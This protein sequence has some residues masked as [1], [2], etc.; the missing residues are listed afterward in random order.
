MIKIYPLILVLGVAGLYLRAY[1]AG[2]QIN[3]RKNKIAS[4]MAIILIAYVLWE[5]LAHANNMVVTV[6]D[7][8]QKAKVFIAA[9]GLMS[10]I[11]IALLSLTGKQKRIKA[12]TLVC[13]VLFS[14]FEFRSDCKLLHS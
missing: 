9:I 12:P 5:R 11:P 7:Y 13:L 14:G 3:G 10:A 1:A 2:N 4:L 6:A 8:S